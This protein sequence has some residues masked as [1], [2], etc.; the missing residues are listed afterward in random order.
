MKFYFLLFIFPLCLNVTALE[1]GVT[2]QDFKLLS[3]KNTEVSLSDFIGKTVVLEWFNHGCPFVR[4]HYNVGNMQDLQKK[5]MDKNVVWLTIN[6][7]AEGKQGYL[8]NALAADSKM[9]EEKMKS[10]YFVIH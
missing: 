10:K 4:K 9:K 5:W 7:S 1:N 6:S 2:V 3:N 8:L